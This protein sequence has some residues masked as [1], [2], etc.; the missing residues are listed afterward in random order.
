MRTTNAWSLSHSSP[1]SFSSRRFAFALAVLLH[2]L[3]FYVLSKQHGHI[4]QNQNDRP[5][6]T[7][8]FLPFLA[9]QTEVPK[10]PSP[11][12]H[13]SESAPV[14][15]GRVVKAPHA[16]Q[17]ITLPATPPVAPLNTKHDPE[18]EMHPVTPDATSLA[19]ATLNAIGKMDRD[20]RGGEG[21]G[22][23]LPAESGT[24]GSRL[25]AAIDKHGAYRAGMI[26]EHIYPDGRREERVHTL[27]GDFC[28][29]YESPDDPKNGVDVMQHG[30]QRSPPHSCGHRFD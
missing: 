26:E 11:Q 22:L 30:V 18:P 10:P 15:G 1:L 16:P 2:L 17:P 24:L 6:L 23:A 7:V 3:F 4:V 9:R 25:S 5:P 28:V 19:Q 12:R 14:Q 29:T 20:E 8:S 13:E 27:L 21:H